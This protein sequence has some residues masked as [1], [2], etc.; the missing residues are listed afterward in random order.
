MRLIVKIGVIAGGIC[1]A[2]GACV[3][4]LA[5]AMLRHF[6]PSPPLLTFP[7]PVNQLEAQR[8]DLR[9]FRE[10]MALDRSFQPTT[11][12][13]AERRIS[14]LEHLEAPLDRP[15]FRVALMEILA[16]ADNGHTRL[17]SGDGAETRKLPVRVAAFADGLFVMRTSDR[18]STL[19]GGRVVAIDGKPIEVVIDRLAGLSGGTTG[20]RRLH[21][22]AYII[23]QDILF[24]SDIVADPVHSTWTVATPEGVTTE[25]MLE[26]EPPVAHEPS[27]FGTRWLS[28]EST[29][30]SGRSW[31]VEHPEGA[32]PLSLREFATP[33]RWAR[34][35]KS[36]ADFVQLKSNGDVG[37]VRI[38]DFIAKTRADLRSAQ[39]C[40]VVLDLRY[41]DGGDYTNTVGFAKEL[42]D[43]IA[44]G[45]RLYLLIGPST[46]S[47]GITTAAFLK[48]SGGDRV[49]I[50]GEPVGDRLTFFSEGNRG[51]LPNY[52]LCISYRR[53][54]HDYAHSCDDWDVCFWLNRLYPV[55]VETLAPDET[56]TMSFAQWRRGHDPVFE[57]AVALIDSHSEAIHP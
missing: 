8:Q 24:G 29:A 34:L 38:A 23:D 18:A 2:A 21:A 25:L 36:C 7:R 13:Q 19:L 57:R 11:R 43:L 22:A 53:G 56:I 33:F 17:D 47:A 49:T 51:C 15:H 32:L 35:A 37:N 27:V 50:L 20:W 26:A 4:G 40:A 39:P 28:S 12:A 52:H 55:R 48:Q 44:P 42:P 45:G 5:Y 3:A 16:L 31:E 1:L 9:Y 46:F 30:D 6:D 41:D 14:M 54:K 10:L